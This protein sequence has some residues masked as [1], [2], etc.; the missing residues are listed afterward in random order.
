MLVHP[1]S[2][3]PDLK[4]GFSQFNAGVAGGGGGGGEARGIFFSLGGGKEL[5]LAFF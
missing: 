3:Q 5:S 2:S 1:S 4:M